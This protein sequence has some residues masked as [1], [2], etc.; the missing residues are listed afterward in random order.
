MTEAEH[1]AIERTRTVPIP[2]TLQAVP[3]YPA[4][5]K[6]YKIAASPFWQ[7]RCYESGRSKR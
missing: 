6:I 7:V 2:D 1:V 4:K 3:G 5:L